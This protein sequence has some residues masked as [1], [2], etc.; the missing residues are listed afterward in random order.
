M[1][2]GTALK[3]FFAALG[4][5]EKSE[6]I[7][8]ALAAAGAIEPPTE[9]PAA[10]EPA[11]PTPPPPRRDSAITLLAALQREA[12][13]IDLI[14]EDLNQYSDAQVGAAARPCLLQCAAVLDRTLGI[15]PLL[16]ASEGETVEVG[17]NPSPT[18][19]QWIGEGTATTGKLVHHG[20]RA[21]KLELPTWTGDAADADVIAAAQVQAP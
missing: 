1:S 18:R 10:A 9:P 20:W 15:E 11:E 8:R 12:R 7:E 3:A 4:N 17:Q 19:Y 6:R 2:L 5:R 21:G 14:R 13:L 16:D